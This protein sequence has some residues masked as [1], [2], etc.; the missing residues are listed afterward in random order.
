[1]AEST[2]LEIFEEN[3]ELYR[4]I[5]EIFFNKKKGND[6]ISPASLKFNQDGLSTDWDQKTIPPKNPH[7]TRSQ[8]KKHPTK[9]YGVIA[10]VVRDVKNFNLKIK[11][12]PIVDD[13]AHT[14]ISSIDENSEHLIDEIIE[15]LA[16]KAIWKINFGAPL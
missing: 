8:P 14:L 11:Y 16:N 1:M 2:D 5:H 15:K 12:N 4:F 9:E 10:F 6:Y 3:Q 13:P 7:Y